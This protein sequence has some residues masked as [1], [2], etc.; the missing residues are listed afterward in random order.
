MVDLPSFL[1]KL[2]GVR[3]FIIVDQPS[4]SVVEKSTGLPDDYIPALLAI[5]K[6]SFDLTNEASKYIVQTTGETGGRT[7][8]V[9]FNGEGLEI[10]VIGDK[11]VAA[12]I[13]FKL[14]SQLP[15]VMDYVK[16]NENVKCKKCGYDLTLETATC[17]RC[18]R[19]IPFIAEQCPFCGNDTSVKKC[20]KHGGYIYSNGDL[21]KGDVGLLMLLVTIGFVVLATS[22][23]ASII[24][25]TL[26]TPLIA[27]GVATAGLMIGL[28]AL[29][30]RRV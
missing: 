22:L 18:G 19:V 30:Y 21:V 17:S 12:N 13:D 25:E 20:P 14:L 5:S 27:L 2:S 8:F 1:K 10:D 26:R 6:Y 9:K 3:W 15:K 24:I 16:R 23:L 7:V 28:G 29:A 4:G 11:V